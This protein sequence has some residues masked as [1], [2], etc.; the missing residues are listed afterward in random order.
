MTGAQL[1]SL[2]EARGMNQ[3]QL[4]E[5][6][7]DSTPG[8]ISRWEKDI[9]AI[10]QWVADKMIASTQLSLPLDRL[11]QLMTYATEHQIDFSTLLA[12]AIDAFVSANKIVQYDFSDSKSQRMAEDPPD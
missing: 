1:K 4:S 8:T 3:I 5:F 10:P 2:R 7:G 11:Q 6:L 9:H 12:R